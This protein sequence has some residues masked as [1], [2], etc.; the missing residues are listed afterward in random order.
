MFGIGFSEFLL[1]VI[2]GI[3]FLG[4]DK[5]PKAIMEIAKFIKAVKKT[6][7]DIK[8]DVDKELAIT[9]AKEKFDETLNETKDMLTIDI[10][11]LDEKKEDK[12]E[13]STSKKKKQKNKNV[14]EEESK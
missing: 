2:I 8:D 10:E 6:A 3:I 13:K 11:N 9:E 14:K 5:L 7:N 12:Q 4:P 1:I